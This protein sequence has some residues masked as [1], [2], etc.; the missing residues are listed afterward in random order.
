[1]GALAKVIVSSGAATIFGGAAFGCAK[2]SKYFFEQS[3][4][5]YENL[6]N[7]L[8][9]FKRLEKLKKLKEKLFAKQKDLIQDM[10][11]LAKNG[12]ATVACTTGMMTTAVLAMTFVLS[13]P[14]SLCYEYSKSQ[15]T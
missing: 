8:K 3:L 13:I 12:G 10:Y 4:P 11:S 6:K 7:S 14:L 9:N 2:A 15:A 5:P 1:M